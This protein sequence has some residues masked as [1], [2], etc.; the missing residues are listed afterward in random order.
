MYYA[1]FK[2]SSTFGMQQPRKHQAKTPPAVKP[3][4]VNEYFPGV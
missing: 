1:E 4:V 2:E 3:L